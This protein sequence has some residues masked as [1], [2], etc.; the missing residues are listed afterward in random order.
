[1]DICL[2]GSKTEC[3]ALKLAFCP[4]STRSIDFTMS[5]CSFHPLFLGSSLIALLAEHNSKACFPRGASALPLHY[6]STT[7]TPTTILESPS[8][9]AIASVIPYHATAKPA[10]CLRR[11]MES[12]LFSQQPL[13]EPY[14]CAPQILQVFRSNFALLGCWRLGYLL[15]DGLCS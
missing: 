2:L 5:T 10:V 4:F 14:A 11:E 15:V 1:M 6:S 3:H 9:R 12:Y 8:D 7:L 13:S